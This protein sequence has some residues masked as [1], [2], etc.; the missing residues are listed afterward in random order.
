MLHCAH[1]CSCDH[2]AGI[3]SQ[4][5]K[6][7]YFANL[8]KWLKFSR[9]KCHSEYFIFVLKKKKKKIAE[10]SREMAVGQTTFFFQFVARWNF[11]DFEKRQTMIWPKF[12]FIGRL[13]EAL[14]FTNMIASIQAC[15]PLW[16][17]SKTTFYG[18]LKGSVLGRKGYKQTKNSYITLYCVQITSLLPKWTIDHWYR[19]FSLFII[20]IRNP[21][22]IFRVRLCRNHFL[23]THLKVCY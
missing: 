23:I 8:K 5:Q 1:S 14:W 17:F 19:T 10:I 21:S 22:W 2:S 16:S 9:N 12:H 13:F 4:L 6:R 7:R 15:L 18:G 3:I 11:Y 20:N